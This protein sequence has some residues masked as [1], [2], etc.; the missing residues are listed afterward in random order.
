MIFQERIS[1]T[2]K[3]KIC[4]TVKLFQ[5]KHM[6]LLILKK[7]NAID[8]PEEEMIIMIKLKR[9]FKLYRCWHKIKINKDVY[10]C[11]HLR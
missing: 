7:Q 10:L 1:P 4:E 3:N 6:V 11:K 9:C 5:E 8:A 2:L